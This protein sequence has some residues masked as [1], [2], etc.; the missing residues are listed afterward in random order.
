MRLEFLVF[1]PDNNKISL[2][3]IGRMQVSVD[4]RANSVT[5]TVSR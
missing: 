1:F 4:T 3:E 5:M 2:W